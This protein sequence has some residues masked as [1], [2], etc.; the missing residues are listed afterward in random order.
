MAIPLRLDIRITQTGADVFDRLQHGLMAVGQTAATKTSAGLKTLAGSLQDV[1]AFAGQM[2]VEMNFI[3]T[4]LESLSMQAGTVTPMS[5]D[6]LANRLENLRFSF[7]RARIPSF[8]LGDGLRELSREDWLLQNA[9][10]EVINALRT[11]ATALQTTSG[12]TTVYTGHTKASTTATRDAA[13]AT[14]NYRDAAMQAITPMNVMSSVTQG[15][16][17]GMGALQGSLMS[18]GFGLIFLRWSIP[19]VT[20]AVAGF[21]TLF[22]G[23][24]KV[25]KSVSEDYLPLAEESIGRIGDAFSFIRDTFV[26]PVWGEILIPLIDIMAGYAEKIRDIA[27]SARYSAEMQERWHGVVMTFIDLLQANKHL[28]EE[29]EDIIEAAFVLA[30]QAA[31]TALEVMMKSIEACI[32]LLPIFV[33]SWRAVADIIGEVTPLFELLGIAIDEINLGEATDRALEFSLRFP[34]NIDTALATAILV[35]QKGKAGFLGILVSLIGDILIELLPLEE[36]VKK[37]WHDAWDWAV[38]GGA[39]GMIGG[40]VGV[41]IGALVGTILSL[42]NTHFEGGIVRWFKE[43]LPSVFSGAAVGAAIGSMGTPILGAI[44]ALVG[45]II[46]GLMSAF[47][48]EIIYFFK[49]SLPDFFKKHAKAFQRDMEEW[50]GVEFGHSIKLGAIPIHMTLEPV[51]T[52]GGKPQMDWAPIA[53]AMTHTL[54]RPTLGTFGAPTAQPMVNVTVSGN[55]FLDQETADKLSTIVE[56]RITGRLSSL[57]GRALA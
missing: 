1:M 6:I 50:L 5:L 37:I 45:A 20:L 16:M 47:K 25:L 30:Y 52:K 38:L 2:P 4:A 11:Q 22:G 39:I 15:L 28:F 55:L 41:A 24:I 8:Q 54:N 56:K 19:P 13:T 51:W 12:A 10:L 33:D 53:K 3:A 57:Y 18:V 35:I 36:G 43:N 29:H 40:P 14:R 17:M 26:G 31:F 32:V 27:T 34:E 44:G 21:V 9:T 42:L 48:E 7:I 46:G 23:V 49:V